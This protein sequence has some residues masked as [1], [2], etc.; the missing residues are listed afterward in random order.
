[1]PDTKAN[2]HLIAIGVTT[3]LLQKPRPL[4]FFSCV[5]A[6]IQEPMHAACEYC[7]W[8]TRRCLESG[9]NTLEPVSASVY[10]N[11]HGCTVIVGIT[12]TF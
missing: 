11:D 8:H 6:I 7:M 4:R 2:M 3:N 12:M 5:L 1:M 10:N 9:P